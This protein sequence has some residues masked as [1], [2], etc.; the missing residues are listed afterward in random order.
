VKLQGQKYTGKPIGSLVEHQMSTPNSRQKGDMNTG[1]SEIDSGMVEDK[2]GVGGNRAGAG[3]P[4]LGTSVM[5]ALGRGRCG[6][7]KLQ[8]ALSS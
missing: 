6:T 3:L 2:E 8:L 1:I 5:V 7:S 4:R